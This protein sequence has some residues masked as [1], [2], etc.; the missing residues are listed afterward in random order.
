MRGVGVREF[1]GPDALEVLELDEV[2]A[3][4]GQVRLRVHAA[5]VN[6]ADTYLR[7]GLQRVGRSAESPPY[8][9]GMTRTLPSVMR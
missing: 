4:P 6:P 9:P 1:G 8:V 3:G 7:S 2:H 5:A